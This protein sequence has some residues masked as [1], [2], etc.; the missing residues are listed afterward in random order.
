M[1]NMALYIT[2][3]SLTQTAEGVWL[4]YMWVWFHTFLVEAG[5]DI[6]SV[7]REEPSVVEEDREQLGHSGT[8]HRLV[9]VVF[10]DLKCR[11]IN[12]HH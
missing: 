8:A 3:Q 10:V 9:V 1:Y 12:E 4:R 5:K 6:V 7:E 2:L 11:G